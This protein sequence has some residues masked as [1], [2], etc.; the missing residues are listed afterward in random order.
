MIIS[1][2]L[3]L[4]IKKMNKKATKI[5]SM[6]FAVFTSLQV[7]PLLAQTVLKGN[8]AEKI[9]PGSELIQMSEKSKIPSLIRF[10]NGSEKDFTVFDSWLHETFKISGNIGLKLISTEHDKI[11]MLHYRYQETINGIPVEGTMY[12]VHVKNNKIVSVNGMLFNEFKNTSTS[13]GL[14][15]PA[16]LEDALGYMNADIYRWQSRDQE[17]LL[18]ETTQNPNATWYPKG[19][20]ML[21][22][23][24]GIYNS[25][26]YRLTYRFDVYADK[27]LKRNYVF[28]DAATGNIILDQNRIEST[29]TPATGY[30]VYSGHRP[31]MTDSY[32]GSYRL[33]ETGRGNGIITYNNLH[34]TSATGT[35]DFTN[36]TTTW[37]DV[38]ANLDQYA[39]DAHWGAEKTYDFYD[40][41]MGR[42]SIDGAG[43]N[44]ISFVH[45]DVGLVN[46]F[47]DG[48]EMNYGD[49]D[50]T[51]SPLTAIDVT[52]HEISHGLTQFTSGLGGSGEDG[53]L[54]E[55]C[56]D[57]MGI[58]IRHFGKGTATIDWLIG[59]EMGGTPFR[60]IANPHS[61][62]NPD[63]Y[64][65]VNWDA[66]T[67]EVHQNSTIDSH[68]FYLVSMG[69][70]GTNDNGSVYNVTAMGI[71]EAQQIWFRMNTVYLTPTSTYPDARTAGIQ[72]AIDLY[73]GCSPEVIAT[74]NAWYAVGVGA[75]FVATPAV[76]AFTANLVT[77][78]A[79]PFTT[80]FNNTSV[81]GGSAMWY[82]GDGTTSSVYSPTHTYTTAGTFNVKLVVSGACGND[83][84]VHSSY[85]TITTPPAP[86]TTPAF[87]CASPSI[88]TLSA[89]GGTTLNW[90]TAPTGGAS[91]HTGTTYTTPSL[92][93]NTTYYVDNETA[94]AA[95]NVGPATTGFGT[96][97][98]HNNS[99]FQYLIF[100]VL[101][102]C[103]IQTV[104]VNSGAAGIRNILLW[105]NT[106]A[107]LQT[108]PINF[109]NGTST[110]TVNIHLTAGTG[111]RLGGTMMNLYRNNTGAAYPY[112]LAG[113][114]NI[115]GSSA[116][117]AYYYY[118]YNWHVVNDPCAS[119]RVP[120]LAS[121]G[122]PTVTYSVAAYDT[123]C[124]TDPAFTLTGGSPAS[125]TYSGAGVSAGSFDPSVAGAG[126]QTISYSVTDIN[127]C[128]N[129]SS[130]NVYVNPAC[131]PLGISKS[132]VS[133]GMALYPNP[134]TGVFTLEL[135]LAEDEKTEI[136]VM[137]AIGQI[138]MLQNHNFISGNNK[139]VLDLSGINKGVYF[140]EV[141]TAT[142]VMVQRLIL[143]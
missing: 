43:Y 50:A 7:T 41:I 96:G 70:S 73:G 95:G 58:A 69:G 71:A 13:P 45:V 60:D 32:S 39:T 36:A 51:Y 14:S 11:G 23:V 12:I 35:T 118:Y 10:R 140:V 67:M 68:A 90:F 122:G 103:T 112:T 76:A 6:A 138:I 85:I 25:E 88:L 72:A 110:V 40:S 94:G 77:S 137:N 53:A 124:I 61:T 107:L 101:Q 30:T 142:K 98:Y 65:G 44:L 114:I 109:A 55:G 134:T 18:K 115:T 2:N 93:T 91:I 29:N 89:A 57:C 133:S 99:S 26:N 131:I 130:Q 100:D 56:S 143:N 83:S 20:L 117:A 87:S 129:S 33:H 17:K 127:G 59:D 123:V 119:A 120:V 15:E 62:G 78:C 46:A 1:L 81:N 84:I 19:E 37:N 139:T 97:A 121:I 64:L 74:T 141:K 28:V 80:T 5:V 47:W 66:A 111:Y 52:G 22:P 8:D 128:T 136:K 125:G 106:G 63:T 135:G 132:T 27:P 116:G 31:I 105:D 49:G 113:V 48:T 38:D 21:A 82:F 4:I 86:T 102:P 75:A 34:A 126:I 16:A 54:N 108:I 104:L 92:S 3:I 42:N 79:L 9:I 24:K